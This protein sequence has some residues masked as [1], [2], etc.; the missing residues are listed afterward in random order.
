MQSES[1]L[2]IWFVML[3]F[4]LLVGPFA[5]DFH[6][7]YP[8]EMYYTDAAV[9][10]MQTGDIQTAYLGNGE[11]RF[12]KPI[13]TYWFVLA[14]FELFGVTPFASRFFFLLAG[15]M[16]IGGVYWAA[17]LM[18]KDT[19]IAQLSSLI[20][21]SY[22]VLI[23]SATRSIPDVLLGMFMAMAALG[24]IGFIR[25]GNDTPRRY[26]WILFLGLALAFEVKG[27]PA[28]A[29]GGLGLIYLSVNPWQRVKVQRVFYF[30]A[31]L[32]G[33]VVASY[34]FVAMYWIHGADYLNS[35][36]EDQVGVRVASRY[37]LIA[38]NLLLAI[39]LM[40]VLFIPW[41]LFGMKGFQKNF[42]KLFY[43]EKAFTGFVVLWLVAILLMSAMVT[44]F[45]ERYLLPVV[46]LSTIWV[47][48]LLVKN[49]FLEK[50]RAMRV[51]LFF[52]IALNLIVLLVGVFFNA[53]LP[54]S[55]W[56]WLQILLDLAVIVYMVSQ[57][58]AISKLPALI[59]FS[60]LL[61]FFGASISTYQIS[62][63]DVGQLV[64]GYAEEQELAK[65]SQIGYLGHL[66]A[67]SKIRIGLGPDFRMVG[68]DEVNFP[69]RFGDF[70][71]LILEEK[72]LDKLPSDKYEIQLAALNW[73]AKY[74]SEMFAALWDGNAEEV[75]MKY[76]KKFY[77]AK[78]N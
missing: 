58:K 18:F 41:F 63:P 36:V 74:I 15:A 44:K 21:A 67:G 40:I 55:N 5:L 64:K 42:K 70:D 19:R 73:D 33:L 61:L 43:E 71:Y 30:P 11:L 66:H 9:R 8:D 34:W 28:L 26:S 57:R 37:L 75:K 47:A 7:H 10:M 60:I 31:V 68:L 53:M 22:P 72:Y 45:Y 3:A 76:G 59:S 65:G 32:V 29:L 20:M 49:G 1:K 6:M 38:K 23:M 35:F 46:P 16:T 13:L 56:I 51:V 48:W 50:V 24:F 17:K 39:V 12:K 27:L 52:F 54:T 77:W 4:T 78:P 25:Y 62:L 69:E 2:S 14:G